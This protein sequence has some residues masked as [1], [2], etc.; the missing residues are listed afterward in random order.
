ME[1]SERN[2]RIKNKFE[3]ALNIYLKKDFKEAQVIFRS[4]SEDEGDET[5]YI[6][7]SRCIY[8]IDNPPEDSWK[9][10]YIHVDK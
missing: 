2:L 4:L 7:S 8:Y 9:G 5:S 6:F 10:V 3:D 1:K